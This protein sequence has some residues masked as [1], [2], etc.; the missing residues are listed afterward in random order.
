MAGLQA[1]ASADGRRS[2]FLYTVQPQVATCGPALCCPR[3]W[4][5]PG[6]MSELCCQR[7]PRCVPRCASIGML[8][9]TGCLCCPLWRWGSA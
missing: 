6:M 9:G 3:D 4:G 8:M 5:Q 2:V 1:A 7:S